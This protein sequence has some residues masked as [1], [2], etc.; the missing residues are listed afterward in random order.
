MFPALG[1][2]SEGISVGRDANILVPSAPT[3]NERYRPHK[4]PCHPDRAKRVEGSWHPIDR[5]GNQKCEDPST[6]IRSLGTTSGGHGTYSVS[7][8]KTVGTERRAEGRPALRKVGTFPVFMG[9]GGKRKCNP[10]HWTKCNPCPWTKCN[11]CAWTKRDPCAWTKC[12]WW[13]L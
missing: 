3:E 4:K 13:S 5:K 8:P 9:C 10:C 6:H 2:N 1:A 11:L 12:G 7:L